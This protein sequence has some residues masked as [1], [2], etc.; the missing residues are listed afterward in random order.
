M[1]EGMLS[2]YGSVAFANACISWDLTLIA[3]DTISPDKYDR[4]IGNAILR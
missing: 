1:R 3:R 2:L 4:T